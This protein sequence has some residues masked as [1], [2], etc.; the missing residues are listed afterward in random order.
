[1]SNLERMLQNHRLDSGALCGF[2]IDESTSN[3][4]F[5]NKLN[6]AYDDIIDPESLYIKYEYAKKKGTEYMDWKTDKFIE[7]LRR[8]NSNRVKLIYYNG[9][10]R[11]MV[12]IDCMYVDTTTESGKKYIRLRKI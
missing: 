11:S 6:S 10:A 8:R 2:P 4:L 5:I 1:M 12:T 3:S 9:T 7:N